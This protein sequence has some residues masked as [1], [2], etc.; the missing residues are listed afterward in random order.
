MA[1]IDL[2]GMLEAAGVEGLRETRKE[3][4]ARCPNPRHLD[5]RPSWSINRADLVH[6][7][8]SCG[9]RGTLTSLLVDLTGA[10]PPDLEDE[11]RKQSFLRRIAVREQP[12]E[13]LEPV[14][15]EWSLRNMLGDVPQRLLELRWL[16]RSAIDRYRVRWNPGT[17]QWVLP[18]WDVGGTLLGAQF[19]QTGNVLTLPAGLPKSTI[20]FGY[21]EVKAGDW[22]VLVESPLDAVRLFGL[23]IPAFATLGAWVSRDQVTLMSRTFSYV[24][25]ALDNDKAGHEGAEVVRPMLRRSGCATIEWDYTDLEDSNGEPAKDVGD[26]PSDEALLT[27]FD[28]TLH[29]RL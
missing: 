15:T 11:L 29:F 27:A 23:G 20:L 12:E 9:Y 6:Y 21:H 16:V 13:I 8:F 26:V 7:C 3:I 5:R 2:F 10:A 14:I 4:V 22:A 17:R 19:R 18:L 1:D 25:L 24:I 28:R